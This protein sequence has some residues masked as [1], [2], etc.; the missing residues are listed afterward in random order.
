M[1]LLHMIMQQVT[2]DKVETDL[3]SYW[4]GFKRKKK[5]KKK[6]KKD[7]HIPIECPF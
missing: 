1:L 7:S 5:R 3:H 6:K 4:M 2:K